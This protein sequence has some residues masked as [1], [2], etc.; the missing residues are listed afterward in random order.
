MES[1]F[2]TLESPIFDSV[3]GME[4]KLLFF[5]S[6]YG[7]SVYLCTGTPASVELPASSDELASKLLLFSSFL[8][9]IP[10]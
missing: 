9:V 3:Q 2:L 4:R 7:S 5:L 6:L 10:S 8:L 1:K